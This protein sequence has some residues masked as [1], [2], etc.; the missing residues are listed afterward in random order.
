MIKLKKEAPWNE[1]TI[2]GTVIKK[3][4]WT[5]EEV[6]YM[7]IK[8]WVIFED[9][10]T[11]ELL[12]SEVPVFEEKIDYSKLSKKEL[13]KICKEKDINYDKKSKSELIEILT[14]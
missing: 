12:P 2:N 8:K 6:N 5:K 3:T 10:N 7:P 9:E 14:K 13:V 11:V 4:K 1:V